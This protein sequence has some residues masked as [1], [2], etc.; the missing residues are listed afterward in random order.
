MHLVC[1]AL[2]LHTLLGKGRCATQ[3]LANSLW[4]R[5]AHFPGC[6]DGRG[7]SSAATPAGLG[8]YRPATISE[9]LT[10]GSLKLELAPLVASALRNCNINIKQVSLGMQPKLSQTVPCAFF[11]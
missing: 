8:R 2:W 7:P 4:G 11:V 1:C 3:S 10:V 5:A 6:M 9:R